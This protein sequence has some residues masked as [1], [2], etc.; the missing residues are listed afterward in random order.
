M[1]EKFK[2]VYKST[3][4]EANSLLEKHGKCAI[5]RP[6]GFGK[7]VMMS[8]I[9]SQFKYEKVLYVYP[10]EI[11]KKQAQRNIPESK[12]TWCTYKALGNYHNNVETLY[13]QIISKHDLI[14]FDEMHH[15]GAAQVKETVSKLLPLIDT[16]RIHI[17]G[18]T[19]T[20][21]RMDGYDVIDNFFDNCITSF[22]GL[23]NAIA[24]GIIQKPV[25]VYSIDGYRSMVSPL[26]KQIKDSSKYL[27]DEKA[28]ADIRS[29]VSGLDK[30]INASNIISETLN[31]IY[32]KG[33]PS[34]MRFMVF[35]N[36][37]DILEKRGQEVYKWFK[38]AFPNYTINQPH[39]VISGSG[40]AKAVAELAKLGKKSNTIDLIYSINMLNE[41]Y[42]IDSI[43]GIVLLRPTQSPT[44]YTQQVGR[45]LQVGVSHH[46]VI[47]DFVS[48]IKIQSLFDMSP[49]T[50]Q[51]SKDLNDIEDQ[52]DNLNNIS[53]SNILLVDKI[54]QVKS[55]IK[56]I[57]ATL[58]NA[59]ECE[60]I[61]MRKEIMCPADFIHKSLNIPIWEVYQI[62][63]KYYDELSKLG[64]Q[65]QEQDKYIMG[66][67]HS[68]EVNINQ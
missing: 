61:R 4:L 44:V 32:N 55:V 52:L 17:I 63:D 60:V 64:L 36:T 56:K 46:P 20:P 14:V 40:S 67:K 54:A 3:L 47:F 11:V 35:Y 18:S 2:Q 7:T 10:S 65:R 6:T 28:R 34:Y 5:L 68:G 21:K 26:L 45:C 51:K 25:Y 15:M 42:H 8:Q 19:A 49:V 48:N 22:Y 58:P 43:T 37:K 50:S 38:E 29:S 9:A 59:V 30:L 1:N 24:D 62:L 41:G 66:D 39:I 13:S 57:E 31:K 16:S 27:L 33:T 23:D 53:V 12:V